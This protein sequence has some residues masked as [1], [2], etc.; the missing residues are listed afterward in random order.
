MLIIREL[1]LMVF[2]GDLKNCTKTDILDQGRKRNH[3]RKDIIAKLS[4]V[5]MIFNP[6]TSRSD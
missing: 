4:L 5:S 6:L 1:I 2:L 3:L